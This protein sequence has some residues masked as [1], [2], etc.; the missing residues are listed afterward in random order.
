MWPLPCP[1]GTFIAIAN[2]EALSPY[3]VARSRVAPDIMAAHYAWTTGTHR[4]LLIP[5]YGMR[6]ILPKCIFARMRSWPSLACS[7]GKVISIG[8]RIWPAAT[9]SQRSLRMLTR[10][11]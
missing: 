7:K 11:S 5:R 6:S 2:I 4:S 3:V 8:T 10:M 9:C 1:L